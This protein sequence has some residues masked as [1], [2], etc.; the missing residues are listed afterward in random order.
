MLNSCCVRGADE[1]YMFF[2]YLR[3]DK[4]YIAHVIS[5]EEIVKPEACQWPYV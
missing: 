4:E 3:E 2:K 1:S 5:V